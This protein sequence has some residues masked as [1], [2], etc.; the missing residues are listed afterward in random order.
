MQ[1]CMGKSSSLTG[2][3]WSAI[4]HLLI[5]RPR[6]VTQDGAARGKAAFV[7]A[8]DA[9]AWKTFFFFLWREE[10]SSLREEAVAGRCV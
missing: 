5:Y 10:N 6:R 1:V 8:A 4:Q 3:S 7:D 2:I 9:L